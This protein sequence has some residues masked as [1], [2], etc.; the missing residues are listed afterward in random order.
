MIVDVEHVHRLSEFLDAY[1]QYYSL[2]THTH[3][4]LRIDNMARGA[5]FS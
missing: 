3:T 4:K 5:R 2:R 1:T